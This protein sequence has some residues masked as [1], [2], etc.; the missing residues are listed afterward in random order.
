MDH[1]HSFWSRQGAAE[2]A[3]ERRDGER[4]L[5]LILGVLFTIVVSGIVV[6]GTMLLHA[7]RQKTE[8]AFRLHGQAAQFGR[9]G[10]IEAL[11]WFRKQTSQ[12]VLAFAP[13]LDA[14]ATPKI[15]DT[16]DPDIGLVRE[17]QISGSTWG[18]YEV[19]KQWEA[20]P[21]P[22][23]LAWR[24]QV[25]VEDVSLARGAGSTGSV[26]RLRC[27]GY[28]FQQMNSAVSF[29][30]PPNRVISKDT[31]ETE[32][33]RMTF[34]P[35]GA[36]TLCVDNLSNLTVDRRVNVQGNGV[37]A[38]YGASGTPVY[39][40]SPT[41]VGG[42]ST[43]IYDSAYESVFGLTEQDLRPLA[44]D[45]ITAD[46]DFPTPLPRNTFFFVEVPT[47]TFTDTRPLTGTG[48]VVV[49]GDVVFQTG[50]KSFFSG[51]LY[52]DGDITINDP[53]EINGTIVCNGTVNIVGTTDWINMT[54]DGGVLNSLRQEIGQ[55]RLSSAIR[56]VHATE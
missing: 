12:P 54:Y 3:T 32:V 53:A 28:V 23:R 20:D 30:T 26:W 18:R 21:L 22:A 46:G 52:V 5:A 31:L 36:A 2:C 24:R 13:L 40:N 38:I 17:F 44:D 48:L 4:G 16:I 55:Y 50:N 1:P 47:L 34:T 6:T 33:R 27:I 29:D 45:R 49:K 41:V 42:W 10:L 39:L 7:H 43:G 8:T 11:G 9:A 35:P 51:M 37:G 25:Q 56:R 14:T 19:W 15:L